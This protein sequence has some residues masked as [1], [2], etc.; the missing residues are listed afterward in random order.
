MCI[1]SATIVGVLHQGLSPFLS[2]KDS[3]FVTKEERIVTSKN[4][5]VVA[6]K[7]FNQLLNETADSAN[8]AQCDEITVVQIR[9]D[10]VGPNTAFGHF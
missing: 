4:F 3:P 1:A 8:L 2:Q 5:T 7:S 10:L 6:S 9:Y